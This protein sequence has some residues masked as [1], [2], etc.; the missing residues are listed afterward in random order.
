MK[1]TPLEVERNVSAS[2]GYVKK[3]ILM[4]N[5]SFSSLYD[6]FQQLVSQQNKILDEIKKI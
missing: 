4:L 3:D 5:D 6:K 1:K 2:F